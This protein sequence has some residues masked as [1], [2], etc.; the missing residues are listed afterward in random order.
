MRYYKQLDGLRAIAIIGVMIAHWLQPDMQVGFF[1]SIP[2]AT[3]VTL[4]FVI[5]GFLITKILLDFKEENNLSGK[6]HFNSIKSFYLR[7]SLRIFPI[8]YLTIFFLLL[9]GFDNTREL[10]PWLTTYTTNIY[11]TLHG[12]HIGSFTHFWSLAVE[13]QFYLFWG[14]VVL[15]IPKIHLKNTIIFTILISIFFLYL[16]KFHSHYWLASTLVICCMHP[17]GLGALIAYFLKYEPDKINAM[18]LSKI[19]LILLGLILIFI[20]IFVFKKPDTLYTAFKDPGNPINSFIYALVV[21]IAVRDGFNGLMKFIVENKW[22]TYIGRIS[23]GLYVYHWFM[24]PLYFRFINKYI[25]IETTTV[26]YFMLFSITCFL[27]A[28]LSW[29]LIEKPIIGWKKYFKY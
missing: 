28:S 29:F 11:M 14:I 7:R 19:K 22:M 1:K 17:L 12:K 6:N 26:G 25:E 20:V 27:I 2:F 5:S 24:K 18:N 4:F 13:E 15:F 23:Y 8:Y 16:F 21:L 10:L 3:G 9:I